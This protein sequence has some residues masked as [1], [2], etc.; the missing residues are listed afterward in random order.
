MRPVNPVQKFAILSSVAIACLCLALGLAI[1]SL[2]EQHM[3]EM[4]WLSTADIVKYE[5]EGHNLIPDLIRMKGRRTPA[6]Y[7][8]ALQ[9]LEHLPEV[10]RIKV[11]DQKATIL[12]SNDAQ[13]IGRR[14]P[15]NLEVKQA[16]GGRAAV[17][18]KGLHEL[19]QKYGREE[20]A[21]LAEI[22]V[23]VRAKP[24]GEILGV[25]EVY[26]APARLLA[27]IRR[28]RILV[29]GI[30]LAGGVL[31]NCGLLPWTRELKAAHQRLEILSCHDG[32][33]SL[34][35][36]REF[37][38]RLAA[39]VERAQ[40]YKRPFSLLLLD[41][42]NFKAVNDT[43]GHQAGDAVLQAMAS[44]FRETVRPTDQVA[45]VGGDEFAI[46]LPET[47]GSGALLVANRLRPLLASQTIPLA[48]GQAITITMS[49][50][51]ATFPQEAESGDGLIRVADRAL[52]A[53]KQA[54]RNRV[55]LADDPQGDG[56]LTSGSL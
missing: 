28:M 48:S 22:Y 21:R 4:E 39:E 12:W 44:L 46:L 13:L 47:P 52:Y 11:W 14:F 49:I 35:N 7:R 53:A 24:S 30:V 23:P 15:N 2:L 51:I 16:L 36:Y 42:D 19:E 29:W 31:L 37:Q 26:K 1:T 56:R 45:R 27:D 38:R 34:C 8:Q 43:F 10:V 54:G 9:S 50:G 5:V 41:I 33:T 18:L 55:G 32:L 40:R 20:F 25:I 3:R 6:G 17:E